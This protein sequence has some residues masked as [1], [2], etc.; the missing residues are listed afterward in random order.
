M[1]G[2]LIKPL[3]VQAADVISISAVP[4]SSASHARKVAKD[5]RENGVKSSIAAG[6]WGYAGVTEGGT[7]A[8]LD[9]LRKALSERI[10]AAA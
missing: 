7:A 4:P 5:S 1:P 2:R 8:R 6:L 3:G 10:A 9:R